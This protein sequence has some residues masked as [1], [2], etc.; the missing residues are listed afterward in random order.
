M[1]PLPAKPACPEDFKAQPSMWYK[2]HVL[3][4]D[5]RNFQ[6]NPKAQARLNTVQDIS[7]IG[8]PCFDPIEAQQLKACIVDTTSN[9]TLETLIEDTLKELL[10]R[11]AKKRA[12]SEDY[13]I[14]AAHDLAPVFEKVFSIKPKD[15]Q[16]NTEFLAL[17]DR[18]QLQLKDTD[19]WKG[20][21]KKSFWPKNKHKKR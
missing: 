6:D 19:N 13:R 12:D 3:V 5:L 10:E 21:P 11:R 17:L 18:S 7:Y 14:C 16:T 15:L 8:M 4:Y 20:L 1:E 9:S 2:I